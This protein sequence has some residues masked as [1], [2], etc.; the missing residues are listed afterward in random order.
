M[1]PPAYYTQVLSFDVDY[2]QHTA[3]AASAV[4][5]NIAATKKLEASTDIAMI[6]S[7]S[8]ERT[9]GMRER[10]P[11]FDVI[12]RRGAE[13]DMPPADVPLLGTLGAAACLRA[14]DCL[15]F[16]RFYSG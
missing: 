2:K 4:H 6:A 3:D 16:R 9:H 11:A 14:K 15:G 13:I 10:A 7:T 1:A 8:D 5:R 12:P